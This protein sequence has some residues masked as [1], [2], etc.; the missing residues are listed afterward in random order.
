MLGVCS[1][2]ALPRTGHIDN[3]I[4]GLHTSVTD[5]QSLAEVVQRREQPIVAV[6]ICNGG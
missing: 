2:E 3:D 4:A 5:K 6:P 1:C